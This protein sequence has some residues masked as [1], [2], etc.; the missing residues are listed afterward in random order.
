M[1]DL[2]RQTMAILTPPP[3]LSV[4]QWADENR[5][6][7]PEASA[8]PGSWSTSRAEYQR[9]IMDA[10]ND[11]SVNNIVVM[12]SAQIGKTEI[13]NNVLGYHIDQDPAPILVVQP[14]L[15]MA[16]AWSK[17]RLATMLRDTPVLQNKVA[18]PRS[19]DS[20][21]TT[22]H[23]VFPGGH[24]TACGANSPSSLASRPIRIVLCD[25]VDRYPV[26]AGAEGDPISLARK[27]SATFWNKKLIMVSTPTVKGQ[28]RIEQ[29]FFESDQREY[30]VPCPDCG[31]FRTL[32]WANV[33]FDKEAPETAAYV[34]EDCGSVWD[35]SKRLRAIRKGEWRAHAP[36]KGTAGFR[37]SAL[38][39]PW[40]SLEDGVRDFLEARK[41]PATLRVW[42]N[43]YLGETWEEEGQRVDDIGV[44]ER[45]EDYGDTLPDGVIIITAGVDVQDDR[46][47]MEIVGWGRNE[48]S[49]SL[50][51]KTIYGDPSSPIVWGELDTHLRKTYFHI[52]GVELPIRS[53]CVDSGGH[54]TQSVYAFCKAR[55][56]RR[57]FA[58]RGVGGEGKPL[59]G[60]PT[61]NNAQRVKLFPVGVD[62]AKE[63][64]YSRLRITEPGAGYCHFPASYDDEYFRQITAEQLVS[65]YHKGFLRREWQKIRPRNEA[66]DC[67]V[68]A[69]AAYSLLNANMN[70]V[71]DKLQSRPTVSEAS[72]ETVEVDQV[73]I[74]I[75]TPIIAR[76]V[77]RAPQ[78]GGFVNGWR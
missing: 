57:V 77:R 32:K 5:R 78:R 30:Y 51:Y 22:L 75:Q 63:L 27:R 50:E 10:V 42:I 61:I 23:K 65:R 69:L 21:N 54:H 1:T 19:R 43:T 71:A 33:Q 46:L 55:E 3:N 48:E 2:V 62:T 36:F 20:G 52:R 8:E 4:S 73:P 16:Q 9:G 68:Y 28:S 53:A 70:L 14:T 72:T 45:R 58:I 7:S 29:A 13:C 41:Q 64:V 76:T 17:D 56:G 44:S 25:E 60:R 18:D 11:P 35:D 34:C 31:E 66:L 24:I 38:Y 12:S 6:L 74:E 40:M 26:S 59:V 67:R 47:E 39:S 49:W 15:D 37:L